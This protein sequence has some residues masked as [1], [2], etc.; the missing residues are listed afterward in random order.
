MIKV[1]IVTILASLWMLS[2]TLSA[3]DKFPS[4]DAEAIDGNKVSLPD[5][6]SGKKSIVFLAFTEEAE[7]ILD[8][9]YAPV[10]TLFI[11][12]SGFNAMAYDCHVKLVM[13]FTGLG[14]SIADQII[15]KIRSNVDESFND[16]LLFYNGPF[17]EQMKALGLKKK[18]DAYVFVLDEKGK[19]IYTETGRYSESKLDKIAD[20]V[21]L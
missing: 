7:Q 16:Y 17:K 6:L 8:N 18:N 15:Q 19:V 21:E 13:M 14:Q 11:D 20:L 10:Y 1:N 9:W 12:E 4:L 3:Q 2:F 5:A